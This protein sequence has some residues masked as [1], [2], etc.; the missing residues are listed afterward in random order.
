MASDAT[1]PGRPGNSSN[2]GALRGETRATGTPVHGKWFPINQICARVFGVQDFAAFFRHEHLRELHLDLGHLRGEVDLRLFWTCQNFRG[3]TTPTH[4]EAHGHG[5]PPQA[6]LKKVK[7][8]HVQCELWHPY[9]TAP[10][11]L[12]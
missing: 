10:P 8:A 6:K 5:K 9:S 4:M 3:T 2:L 11:H 7:P 12:Q 1:P